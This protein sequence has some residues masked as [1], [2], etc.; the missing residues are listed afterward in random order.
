VHFVNFI[1]G[2]RVIMGSNNALCRARKDKKWSQQEVA[3]R[4]GVD[5]RTYARWEQGEAIPRLSSLRELC[6]VFN[7]TPDQ[8]GFDLMAIQ[9]GE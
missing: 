4:V 2:I 5:V 9:E 7:M 8:L 3:R 1:G 6:K